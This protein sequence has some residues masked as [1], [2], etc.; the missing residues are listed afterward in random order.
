[1]MTPGQVLAA[2]LLAMAVSAAGTWQVQGW[3]VGK[4]QLSM[5]KRS[6]QLL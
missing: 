4:P 2:I 6:S 5:P 3:R 1:M